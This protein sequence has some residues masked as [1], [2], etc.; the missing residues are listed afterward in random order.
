MKVSDL[1]FAF[2]L[3]CALIYIVAV[4]LLL[5]FL[6]GPA[7]AKG[8]Q[9]MQAQRNGKISPSEKKNRKRTSFGKVANRKNKC[10]HCKFINDAQEEYCAKCGTH[11][12]NTGT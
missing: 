5:V 11:L 9:K 10:P 7:I 1:G 8:I 6:F 3:A 2:D 12:K 4:P